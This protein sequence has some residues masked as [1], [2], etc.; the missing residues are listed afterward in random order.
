MHA[1]STVFVL[2]EDEATGL[3]V[4]IELKFASRISVA[5]VRGAGE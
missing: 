3:N 5:F 2:V 4:G 1:D